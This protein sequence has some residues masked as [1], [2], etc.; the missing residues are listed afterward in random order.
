M[1]WRQVVLVLLSLLIPAHV[2]S[3]SMPPVAITVRV[4]DGGTASPGVTRGSLE[5][6]RR[7]LARAAVEMKWMRCDVPAA[8]ACNEPVASREV[9]L[10]FVRSFGPSTLTAR[11]PLGDAFVDRAG[12]GVLATVYVDRVE[13][14]AETS[15][16]DMATLLGRAV[17]HEI[18]HLLLATTAHGARGLMRAAWSAEELRRGRYGDWVF[19]RE[20]T[21]AIRARLQ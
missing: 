16:T 1:S 4:Y 7:T 14:L 17:A 19:T 21:A 6:A 13:Q 8:H 9:V 20:E 10:R 3:G 5:V 11:V 18:G 15:G 12:G 2:Y